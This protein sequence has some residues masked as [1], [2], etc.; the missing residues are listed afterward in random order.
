MKNQYG[1]NESTIDDTMCQ[2]QEVCITAVLLQQFRLMSPQ[3]VYGLFSRTAL[4][5]WCQKITSGLYGAKE[6]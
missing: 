3:P 5:S 1:L 4:V 6:D 2:I